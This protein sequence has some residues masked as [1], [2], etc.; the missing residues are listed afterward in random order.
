MY[1]KNQTE[2][3]KFGIK[4]ATEFSFKKNIVH[5]QKEKKK[6]ILF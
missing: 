3:K 4:A 6:K 5:I 2:K 1:F